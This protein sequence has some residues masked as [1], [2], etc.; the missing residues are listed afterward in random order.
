MAITSSTSF[1]LRHHRLAA[2][3]IN[4]GEPALGAVINFYRSDDPLEST[5]HFA[6]FIDDVEYANRLAAAINEAGARNTRQE[7][8]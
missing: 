8:A 3:A 2:R 1:Y 7:A 6:L 5:A 4:L